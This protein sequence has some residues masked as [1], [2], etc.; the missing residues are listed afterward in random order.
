L[1]ALHYFAPE[2]EEEKRLRLE[3]GITTPLDAE[4]AVASLPGRSGVNVLNDLDIQMDV[5]P[6]AELDVEIDIHHP[7]HASTAGREQRD[8]PRYVGAA[9]PVGITVPRVHHIPVRPHSVNTRNASAS[10]ETEPHASKPDAMTTHVEHDP[11]HVI[12]H[13]TL[14]RPEEPIRVDAE[15]AAR[16]S[17]TSKDAAVQGVLPHL[18]PGAALSLTKGTE[19]FLEVPKSK[20]TV[21]PSKKPE[22][23]GM[24]SKGKGKAV[25]EDDEGIPELDSGS[26]DGEFGE[27]DE[28]EEEEEA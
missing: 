15:E 5:E 24:E 23:E 1:S 21:G 8:D 3:M 28:D 13:A 26:S 14:T 18:D 12:P 7:I 19:G 22:G 10:S 27:D 4:S 11:R 2:S 6:E 25:E 17:V 20:S 16:V 9:P